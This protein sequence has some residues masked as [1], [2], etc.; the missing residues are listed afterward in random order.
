MRWEANFQTF[1]FSNS[2]VNFNDQTEK[3][4][5]IFQLLGIRR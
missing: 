3:I 2:K 5:Q 4:R 1:Y